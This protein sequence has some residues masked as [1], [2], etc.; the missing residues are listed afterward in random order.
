MHRRNGHDRSGSFVHVGCGSS[1]WSDQNSIFIHW[2]VVVFSV[3]KG[4][5]IFIYK[6]PNTF[7]RA[8][9]IF[10][11]TGHA[12][13]RHFQ[14]REGTPII[15][16]FVPWIVTSPFTKI[17]KHRSNVSLAEELPLVWLLLTYGN[18]DLCELN[19]DVASS[20]C[21][22]LETAASCQYSSVTPA[23]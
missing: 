8:F 6:N 11:E 1:C 12:S 4:A 20:R 14:R 21:F 13:A 5:K 9:F 16:S 15:L 2:I 3:A 7:R 22:F 17:C 18:S 10:S 19:C 23:T